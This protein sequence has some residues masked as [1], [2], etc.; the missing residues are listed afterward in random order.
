MGSSAGGPL[1]WL[2]RCN[3]PDGTSDLCGMRRLKNRGAFTKPSNDI[4]AHVANRGAYFD[5][6]RAV[7]VTLHPADFEK[8][9]AGAQRVR[10]SRREINV[11]RWAVL[12]ATQARRARAYRSCDVVV[13]Y[14]CEPCEPPAF[15]FERAP[16]AKRQKAARRKISARRLFCILDRGGSSEGWAGRPGKIV[17][18]FFTLVGRQAVESSLFRRV[19]S[20]QANPREKYNYFHE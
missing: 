20:E 4:L 8:L 3:D 2:A 13:G 7:C 1:R 11:I 14:F 15:P 18:P 10:Q 9:S 19:P 6:R 17:C 5:E 16:G 12:E